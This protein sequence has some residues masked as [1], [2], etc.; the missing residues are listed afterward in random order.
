VDILGLPLGE[1]LSTMTCNGPDPFS[2]KSGPIFHKL[3]ACEVPNFKE[4]HV[5]SVKN[6]GMFMLSPNKME[7]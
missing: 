6:C 4:K 5:Y 7:R 1:L 3:G 2:V